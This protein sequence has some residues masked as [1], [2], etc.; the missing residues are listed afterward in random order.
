MKPAILPNQAVLPYTA[1][2]SE[3][4]LPNEPAILANPAVASIAADPALADPAGESPASAPPLFPRTARQMRFA[5][6]DS[7]VF[8]PRWQW[9]APLVAMVLFVG[10]MFTLLWVLRQNEANRQESELI[11]DVEWTQQ[12]MRLHLRSKRDE[13]GTLARQASQGELTEAVFISQTQRFMTANPEVVTIGWLDAAGNTRWVGVPDKYISVNFLRPVTGPGRATL[14]AEFERAH[15][16]RQPVYS[17]PF[18]GPDQ[19]MYLQ[20]QLPV[21]DEKNRF[22]GVLGVVY[23]VSNLL[24]YVVPR[25]ISEKYKIA[26][27]NDEGTQ[28][29]TLAS[30]RL[31]AKDQH[32]ELPFDPPG[33]GI[34]IR[35]YPYPSR[36][37][38]ADNVLVW[39]V[40][41]LSIFIMWSLWSLMRHTQRRVA[42]ESARDRLFNLSL[43]ILCIMDARGT[44][45]RLNPAI[46][47]VLGHEP[48]AL[49]G[50]SLLDLVHPDDR[51][52]TEAELRKLAAGKTGGSFENRCRRLNE[53][54]TVEYRWLVWAFNPDLQAKPAA[55][56]LYAVAHDVTLLRTRQEALMAE[57]AFRRAM[58]DS[59]LTGMRAFDMKGRITYV[60]PA[61]CRMIGREEKELIGCLPPYPYWA[62]GTH[63][64]HQEGLDLILVGKAPAAGIEVRV[65]RKDGRMFDARMYVSPLIDAHGVQTGWMTSMTDI[66]EP[67]RIREELAAAHDRFTTVLEELDAAVSVYGGADDGV[68][69]LFANRYYRRR[70]G[71]DAAGH[72]E[73]SPPQYGPYPIEPGDAS[74]M[75]SA[76]ADK[77]FEVRQRT[78]QWVDGRL[79]QMQVATDITA[80]KEAEQLARQ[81]EEKVQLTSRL[82]TMGEMA[83]SLAHELNQPLTAIANYSMGS[84]ARVRTSIEAGTPCDPH[85]LLQIL[86]KTTA[87]AERAGKIIRRIREFVK[88]S[89]PHRQRCS[90]REIV[91]DAVGFAEIE[92]S[93]QRIA[94][95]TLMSTSAD[96]IDADPILIEQVLL[97]LLKNGAEAMVQSAPHTG[98]VRELLL[99]VQDLGSH[100]EFAVTDSGPGIA[101]GLQEKLFEPFFSTKSEGM[102][103]GLN[104]CRSIIEFHHGRLWVENNRVDNNPVPGCTF[105]FTLPTIAST[106]GIGATTTV[107]DLAVK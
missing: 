4:R 15:D 72:L 59:M 10:V 103:M 105:R 54:G 28:L 53:D 18:K 29:A 89:E 79:V 66:T 92:T 75:Y 34:L 37:S 102:G 104:I 70:L 50:T 24:R 55:R 93:K 91:D 31:S 49:R 13:L 39:V 27:V 26:L 44:L 14:M 45:M 38:L 96:E 7:S 74:E 23:S 87:Q 16:S 101:P 12:V 30:G 84:V 98:E 62:Q 85:E 25:D 76:R 68:G 46:T 1:G 5:A 32:Y 43:D 22:H 77:W 81:Q 41:L 60:N 82:I 90:I 73:L 97:N 69:L 61:F 57:T 106:T 100:V 11:R 83:S 33:R 65:M 20:M 9:L 80:R 8:G 86:Q 36:S 42:A 63:Q 78:I 56:L 99:R 21:H 48:G 94:I 64:A 3:T 40:A 67:K 19:E 107:V 88:R 71:T 51:N 6:W 52:G 35:A 47:R 2:M 17:E 95:R 58:E